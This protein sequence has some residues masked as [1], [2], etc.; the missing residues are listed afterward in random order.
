MTNVKMLV[1]DVDGTLTDGK[2]YIS[3]QG[4]VMKA[5]NVKDGYGIV[6]L[7]D[8]GVIPVIITG[9]KSM[10]LE[11]RAEELRINEL[12]QGI[13]NKIIK[14]KEVANKYGLSFNEIAYIGDD[15][16]DLDCIKYCGLTACPNDAVIEIKKEVNYICKNNAGHGAVREFID[17]MF[18]SIGEKNADI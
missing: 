2:I 7:K 12:Y 9:R 13:G 11:K 4:E 15:L 18:G 16:N 6:N 14:L 8:H 5:F 1:M 10:I 3:D 17:Y